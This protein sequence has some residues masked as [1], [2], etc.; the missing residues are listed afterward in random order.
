[1]GGRPRALG[2]RHAR[3]SGNL[4]SGPSQTG[5]AFVLRDCHT[6][7]CGTIPKTRARVSHRRHRPA[8]RREVIPRTGHLLDMRTLDPVNR[9]ELMRW[10]ECARKLTC[11]LC[12]PLE[13]EDHVVQPVADVSP[14]KW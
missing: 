6:L 7:R 12:E 9:N 5:T 3:R 10:Y 14:P 1:M 11:E 2:C 4:Q 13:I 8:I